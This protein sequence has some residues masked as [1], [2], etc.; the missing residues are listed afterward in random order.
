[1]WNCQLNVFIIIVMVLPLLPTNFSAYYS[2]G[3]DGEYLNLYL[4]LN[5]VNNIELGK[6]G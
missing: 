1:M 4:M 6:V 5:L 2:L 3:K